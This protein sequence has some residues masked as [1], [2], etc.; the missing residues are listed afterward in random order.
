MTDRTMG[1]LQKIGQ[2]R[3]KYLDLAS[4]YFATAQEPRDYRAS[5]GFVEAWE[6][7]LEPGSKSKKEFLQKKQSIEQDKQENIRRWNVWKEKLGWWEQ[8]DSQRER[9]RIESLALGEMIEAARTV[10]VDNGL[11]ND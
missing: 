9:D 10:S 11:F 7:T 2:D 3:Y 4:S 8:Y 5:Q 1:T 6:F